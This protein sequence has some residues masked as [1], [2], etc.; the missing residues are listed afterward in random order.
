MRL[1]PEPVRGRSTELSKISPNLR[2]RIPLCSYKSSLS[3]PEPKR[4]SRRSRCGGALGG[5]LRRIRWR[6]SRWDAERPK[7][8]LEPSL[9]ALRG[10]RWLAPSRQ[11]RGPGAGPG[12]GLGP[13]TQESLDN[14]LAQPASE[15]SVRPGLVSSGP[16]R[17]RSRTGQAGAREREAG[18]SRARRADG[19]HQA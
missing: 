13:A 9:S 6:R 1:H 11:G 14:A 5:A 10:G 15:L 3:F 8:G 19:A 12:P 7:G 18:V 16:S 2:L 17:A 4:Y